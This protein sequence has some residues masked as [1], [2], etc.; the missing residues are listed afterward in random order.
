VTEPFSPRTVP[1]I[2]PPATCAFAAEGASNIKE[3]NA[4][5]KISI[6]LKRIEQDFVRE[7]FERIR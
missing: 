5:S 2:D 6:S 7:L 1:E 4:T 3:I